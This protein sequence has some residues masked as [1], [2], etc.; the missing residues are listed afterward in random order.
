M[1]TI[2][3]P[4]QRKHEI[5]DTAEMLFTSKGYAKTTIMDILNAVG[6]AKGTFYYYFKSKEEVMDA[7]IMRIIE[8]DAAMARRIAADP[9]IPVLGKL[10]QILMAQSPVQGGSKEKMI[11]QFHQ[12]ENAEMHQKSLVQAILHLGPVL[13]DV[14]EQG[15]KEGLF[16]TEYPRETVEF[17]LA[18][19]QVIF[20]EGLFQWPQEEV[21]RRAAAF[22][23]MIEQSL[24]AEQGSFD[25]MLE[26]L[27]GPAADGE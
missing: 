7:I 19:A 11:E 18:G 9:D 25:F 10:L 1:R 26:R 27:A 23:R 21:M 5:L 13:A 4:E 22:V 16:R 12:P 15:V 14:V 20:D 8:A 6:I 24:G 17:L 3:A 2:K